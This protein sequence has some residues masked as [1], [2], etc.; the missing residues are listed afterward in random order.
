MEITFSQAEKILAGK[1]PFTMLGFSMLMTRLRRTY[2]SNPSQ[3][4]VL[5]CMEEINA[6]LRKYSKIMTADYA[7]ISKL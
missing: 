2:A 3:A 1:F 6:F 7:V 4:T 5:T